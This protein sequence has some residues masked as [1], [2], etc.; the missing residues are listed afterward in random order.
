[1]KVLLHICCGI[2]AASV[3]ERLLAEGHNVTGFFSNPNIHPAD[4]YARR[5]EVAKTVSSWLKIP[6][7]VPEYAPDSWFSETQSLSREPEGGARCA[8]C[9]RLRLQSAANYLHNH[10]FEAFTTTLT[11][12]PHK[13]AA[14]I[15]KIGAEI[16]GDKF[17]ERDFKK[18]DGFKRSNQIARELGLY[19]QHYCGCLYSLK[20]AEARRA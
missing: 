3:G 4:E 16:A 10:D 14:L 2:C 15:N 7:V 1:M 9:F 13:S 19:H 17:L 6:L 5:L 18:K 20:E 12:S 8:V 11:V